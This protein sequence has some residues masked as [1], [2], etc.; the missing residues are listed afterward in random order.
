MKTIVFIVVILLFF[1]W[2]VKKTIKREGMSD[3]NKYYKNIKNN[4]KKNELKTKHN[5]F[6]SVFR[7]KPLYQYAIKSSYN[8]AYDGKYISDEMVKY[9]LSRGCRFVDFEVYLKSDDTAVVGY[10][11][12]PNA[13]NPEN[14]NVDE[15][16]FLH[17]LKTTLR[18]AFST[19]VNE[20]YQTP[21]PDD[22]LFINIRL[23]TSSNK[24]VKLYKKVQQCITTLYKQGY[25]SYYY[26]KPDNNYIQNTVPLKKMKKKAIFIF[27]NNHKL[28]LP[29]VNN[30]PINLTRLNFYNMTSNT[31][32][33]TKKYF[34]QLILNKYKATPPTIDDSNTISFYNNKVSFSMAFP[35]NENPHIFCFIKNYG[36]QIIMMK[37]YEWNHQLEYYEQMFDNYGSAFVPMA[38]LINYI[39]N[40][41]LDDC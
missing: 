31:K 21:N 37:Y 23:K 19:Q 1:I 32:N 41:N 11:S 5:I 30:S 39:H 6:N 38:Y 34:S 35:D 9:V 12:E 28:N 2:M 17:I 20:K 36:I 15:T 29:M 40:Y 14:V 3:E 18:C 16:E 7:E 25:Q 4:V 33:I 8:T 10:S 13:I 26:Q 24:M 27:E 22:P